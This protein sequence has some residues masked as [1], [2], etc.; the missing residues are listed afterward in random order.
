MKRQT[1]EE[2]SFAVLQVSRVDGDILIPDD[3]DFQARYPT[4]RAAVQA[5]QRFDMERVDDHYN[6]FIVV[7]LLTAE[8]TA[9]KK[10]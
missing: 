1:F 10:L 3:G 8:V 9:R 7:R 5:K 4:R 6:R 2:E